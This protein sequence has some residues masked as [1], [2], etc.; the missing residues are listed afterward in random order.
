MPG[1]RHRAQLPPRVGARHGDGDRHRHRHGRHRRRAPRRRRGRA[2]LRRGDLRRGR[3]PQHHRDDRR[4]PGRGPGGAG[5]AHRDRSPVLQGPISSWIFVGLLQ[6][7]VGYIQY[8]NDVPALLVGVHVAGATVLWAMTVWVVPR[9]S[10]SS[11]VAH[12]MI[13]RTGRSC[14][15][16]LD[17]RGDWELSFR[18]RRIACLVVVVAAAVTVLGLGGPAAAQDDDDAPQSIQGRVFDEFEEDGERVREPVPD[19]RIVVETEAGEEVGEGITDAEGAYVVGLAEPGT[20]V[21]RID[22]DSLPR[23]R[24]GRGGRG[25]VHE[26]RRAE[27]HPD[28]GVLPRRG[29]PLRRQQVGRPPADPRQ[30]PEAGDDHRD[31]VGRTL[32]DLRHDRT[33]PTSPTARWSRSGASW[34]TC[35]T[36]RSGGT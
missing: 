22:Q 23:G 34:R 19:V 33:C 7:A 8:F 9:R 29:S 20:Y 24:C 30:R 28:P 21:V 32:A 25:L 26:D 4:R 17:M 16:A 5:A 1:A 27:R 11:P 35:S 6:A 15:L 10:G 13:T 3:G 18:T 12:R 14:T 36:G 2:A 31:D